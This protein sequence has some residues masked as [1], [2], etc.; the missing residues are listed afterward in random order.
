MGPSFAICYS[1]ACLVH[2]AAGLD[3]SWLVDLKR[4]SSPP[5]RCRRRKPCSTGHRSPATRW[6]AGGGEVFVLM[7]CRSDAMRVSEVPCDHWLS[8]WLLSLCTVGSSARPLQVASQ[9]V[10]RAS[11]RRRVDEMVWCSGG[12]GDIASVFVR[13]KSSDR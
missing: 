1:Y 4:F 5:R 13:T 11:R 12:L 7:G 10:A 2:M 6:I 8:F 9:G 3:F